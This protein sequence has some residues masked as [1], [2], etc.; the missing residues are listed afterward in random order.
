MSTSNRRVLKRPSI[1]LDALENVSGGLSV[2]HVGLLRTQPQPGGA[3]P[4]EFGTPVG[5]GAPPAIGGLELAPVIS[6]MPDLVGFTSNAAT[7]INQRHAPVIL[8]Q[9]TFNGADA[10]VDQ[11]NAARGGEAL[12]IRENGDGILTAQDFVHA[13]NYSEA[14]AV[15]DVRAIMDT[16][17]AQGAPVL[18]PRPAA[19]QQQQQQQ[20]FNPMQL[21]S[22]L[23]SIGRMLGGG[24]APRAGAST[25]NNGG[26]NFGNFGGSPGGTGGGGGGTGTGG[27]EGQP[28]AGGEPTGGAQNDPFMTGTQPVPY[29]GNGTS[30]NPFENGSIIPNGTSDPFT[31]GTPVQNYLPPFG[32]SGPYNVDPGASGF[33]GYTFNNGFTGTGTGGATGSGD[34]FVNGA[35]PIPFTGNGMSTNPYY[36]G[37]I[38]PNGTNGTSGTSGF[39]GPSYAE[40]DIIPNGQP[41]IEGGGGVPEGQFFPQT[42]NEFPAGG[43]MTPEEGMQQMFNPPVEIDV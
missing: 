32:S 21:V 20:A 2:A 39:P 11:I 4:L 33:N 14:A 27:F 40:G 8:N 23:G 38:V 7:F 43:S 26:F 19:Q 3:L 10:L 42:Q 24:G 36:N 1:H 37:S 35:E 41:S 16:L 29:T 31:T 6:V 34:P 28:F 9:A 22:Q 5:I 12:A 30:T 15:N 18:A 13:R 25:G 17:R